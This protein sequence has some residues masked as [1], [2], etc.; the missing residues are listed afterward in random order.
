M[1]D[2]EYTYNLQR[3]N[4]GLIK[5]GNNAKFVEWTPSNTGKALHDEIALGRSLILDPG[6]S[7]TW[8][9]TVVKEIV[10]VSEEKIHFKTENS[11]YI[12]YINN[13]SN[14]ADI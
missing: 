4:D 14:E 13:I 10:E 5:R 3:V 7:Y 1:I 12:L 2:A 9:T 8:L 6:F 11:E